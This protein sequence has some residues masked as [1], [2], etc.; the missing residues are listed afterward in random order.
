MKLDV[1]GSARFSAVGSGTYSTDLN[2]TA[3]GTLTTAASDLALKTNLQPI[4]G[5]LGRINSINGYFFNLKDDPNGSRDIGL[6]AQD[7]EKVVPELVFTNQTDGYKGI[8]YSRVSALLVEGIKELD[9]KVENL[10]LNGKV[11]IGDTSPLK[12][13]VRL[14]IEE[15]IA[16]DSGLFK[17]LTDTQENPEIDPNS[18]TN[19]PETREIDSINSQLASHQAVLDSLSQTLA[20]LLNKT[21]EIDADINPLVTSDIDPD[22][23]EGS[24]LGADIDLELNSPLIAYKDVSILGETTLSN[25]NVTGILKIGLLT[26][27]GLGEG[28]EDNPAQ[29][30]INTLDSPLNFMDNKITIDTKGNLMVKEGVIAGNSSFRDA[31][32]LPAGKDTLQ[33]R[34][35]T[36]CDNT[37]ESAKD[38]E[39]NTP[40]CVENEA[41]WNQQPVTINVTPTYNTNLWVEDISEEGFT[42]KVAE[43]S[44]IDQEIF[45]MAIW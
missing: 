29:I 30:S 25:L 13:Q 6:V 14:A 17:N 1:V 41:T 12:D 27:E 24:S 38:S 32:T 9:T 40:V 35:G 8:N 18:D 31:L 26:I 45:Y 23:S 42:I 44:E 11:G 2:L 19:D 3:D 5:A 4:E 39:E 15:L 16:T 33:V 7:V 43:T 20:E 37:S 36:E 21:P 34:M 10:Q 22:I 28:T